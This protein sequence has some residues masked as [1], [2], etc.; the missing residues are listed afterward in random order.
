MTSRQIREQIGLSND[1][2]LD[3][4]KG[5]L[6]KNNFFGRISSLKPKLS[7]IQMRIRRDWCNETWS[8]VIFSDECPFY[9][10]SKSRCY[11]R[12]SVGQRLVHKYLH[13]TQK[14]SPFVM[15]WGAIR[16]DAR[17]ILIRCIGNVGILTSGQS[18]NIF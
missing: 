18:T 1:I 17:R 6:R 9:L 11:V 4:I 14:F 10:N 13:R 5:T 12:R 2:S 7:R 8:K 16:N 3:T 15:A